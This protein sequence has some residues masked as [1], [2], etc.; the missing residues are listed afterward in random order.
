MWLPHG[1]PI[2]TQMRSDPFDRGTPTRWLAVLP[3]PKFES[4]HVH[5]QTVMYALKAKR[6][7]EQDQRRIEGE[8]LQAARNKLAKERR[9]QRKRALVSSSVPLF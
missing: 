9:D 6:Q 8:K 2:H 3:N 1:R 7:A 4:L 5:P